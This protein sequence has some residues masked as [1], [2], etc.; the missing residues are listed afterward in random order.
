MAACEVVRTIKS[1]RAF[2]WVLANVL[3]S[4]S[5]WPLITPLGPVFVRLA[6]GRGAFDGTGVF[7]TLRDAVGVCAVVATVAADGAGAIVMGLHITHRTS[8]AAE[9]CKMCVRCGAVWYGR[10][11]ERAA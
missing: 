9:T 8:V 6:A 7:W 1:K 11:V 2:A 5:P 3:L 4:D 10:K